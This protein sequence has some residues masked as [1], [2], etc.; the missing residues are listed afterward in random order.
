M[1][2]VESFNINTVES[3]IHDYLKHKYS[4]KYTGCIWDPSL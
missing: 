1:I 4:R 2:I 3:L